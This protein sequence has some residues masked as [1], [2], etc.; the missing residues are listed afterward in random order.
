MS[1]TTR[2]NRASRPVVEGPIAG[3]T[4]RPF[5]ASTFFDLG[6]VGYSEA[7]YFLSGTATAYSS[8]APL[9][10]DGKWR[11]SPSA[12]AT[13][14][15]RVVVYRPIDSRRFNGT[16]IVEWLNV[17]GGLDAAPDW[18]MGHTQLIRAVTSGWVSRRSRSVS[19]VAVRR[20]ACPQFR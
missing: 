16:V 8:P 4:G 20:W 19:R 17:S 3:G 9:A 2:G 10:G 6:H 7:E 12:T 15:T 13:Y 5:V 18:I 1:S 14:R 11:V